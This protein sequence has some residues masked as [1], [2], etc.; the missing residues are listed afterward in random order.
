MF[1]LF[2]YVLALNYVRHGPEGVKGWLA[3][4]FLNKP[5]TPP[6]DQPKA[7]TGKAAKASP[8]GLRTTRPRP[9]KQVQV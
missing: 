8:G 6:E 4:K 9:P 5:W 1:G 3:A 2:L 7:A